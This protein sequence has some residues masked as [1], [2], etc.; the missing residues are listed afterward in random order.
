MDRWQGEYRREREAISSAQ[1]ARAHGGR[2]M[3]QSRG[4]GAHATS[5]DDSAIGESR[6]LVFQVR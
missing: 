1:G 5:T 6:A 4:D 3:S 2:D